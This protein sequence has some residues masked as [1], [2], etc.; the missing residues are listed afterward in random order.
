[1]FLIDVYPN[2]FLS[3][4]LRYKIVFDS[5]QYYIIILYNITYNIILYVYNNIILHIW[6]RACDINF[7]PLITLENKQEKESWRRKRKL[8]YKHH[9][10]AN[11]NL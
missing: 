6:V 7:T 2:S 10:A 4:C 3:L 5:A 1:M 8:I 11:Q 9:K